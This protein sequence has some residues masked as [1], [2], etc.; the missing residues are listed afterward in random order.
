MEGRILNQR[1]CGGS[2][3][4][5]LTLHCMYDA[6]ICLC[7]VEKILGQNLILRPLPGDVIGI[8]PPLIITE[9]EIDDIFDRTTRGLDEAEIALR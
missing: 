1:H 6:R 2:D 4:R 9:K 3:L 7:A 5:C 8:C